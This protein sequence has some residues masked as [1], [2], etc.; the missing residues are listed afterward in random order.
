MKRPILLPTNAEEI[1]PAFEQFQA[2]QALWR[3]LAAVCYRTTAPETPRP[4]HPYRPLTPFTQADSQLFYGREWEIETL[5]TAVYTQPLIA[6]IGESGSGKTSLIQAGLLPHLQ[7]QQWLLL[8]VA[9]NK[10]PFHAL[11]Q[12]ILALIDSA[13]TAN[14][15]D[16]LATAL[17]TNTVPLTAVWQQMNSLLATHNRRWLIIIDALEALFAPT[18]LTEGAIT[19]L[20]QLL[21]LFTMGIEQHITLLFAMRS[22][23]L[24]QAIRYPPFSV[25]LYEHDLQLGPVMGSAYASIIKQPAARFGASF[26]AGLVKRIQDDLGNAPTALPLLQIVLAKLWN[27]REEGHLT[28]R[29]YEKAGGVKGILR[30]HAASSCQQLPPADQKAARRLI[31]TLSIDNTQPRLKELPTQQ[32]A[33]INFLTKQRILTTGENHKAQPVVYLAHPFFGADPPKQVAVTPISTHPAA[34]LPSSPQ[35]AVP[36]APSATAMPTPQSTNPRLDKEADRPLQQQ[37]TAVLAKLRHDNLRLGRFANLLSVALAFTL[38]LL[39]WIGT[40]TM[41]GNNSPVDLNNTLAIQATLEVQEAQAAISAAEKQAVIDSSSQMMDTMQAQLDELTARELAA[42]ALA[43]LPQQTDEAL[44]L[45]YDSTAAALAAGHPPHSALIGALYQTL[46]QATSSHVLAGHSGWITTVAYAPNGRFLLT[47]DSQG[48]AKLWR[49]DGRPVAMLASHQGW[50]QTAVFHPNSSQI[51]TAATDGTAR[52]WDLEGNEL[53]VLA[54]SGT[55]LQTAIYHPSGNQILT[56]G[57]DGVARLWDRQGNLTTILT[58][59][60]AITAAAFS[61]DGS[62]IVTG[63]S[64]GRI[65]LWDQQ[66]NALETLSGHSEQVNAIA[67]RN[68]SAVF[69]SVSNDNAL[70]LWSRQGES[71]GIIAGHSDDVWQVSFAPSGTQLLTSSADGTARLWNEEGDMLTILR[72]TN[73]VANALYLQDGTQILTISGDGQARLWQTDGTFL[74]SFVGH[75]SGLTAVSLAPDGQQFATASRDATIRLWSLDSRETAVFAQHAEWVTA[76]A[77]SPNGTTIATA[78]R[79]GLVQL[80]DQAGN[81]LSTLAGHQAAI[82]HLTF[83][84]NGQQLVTA[85]RDGYALL[86]HVDGTLIAALEG[87]QDVVQTAVFSPDGTQILTASSDG[88]VK[89][90]ASEGTLIRTLEAAAGP[91][92]AAHFSPAGDYIL[93]TGRNGTA[94]LWLATGEHQAS[95]TAHTDVVTDAAFSPAGSFFATAGRDGAAHLWNLAG[96]QLATLTGHTDWI[97]DIAIDPSG[98]RLVTASSD[99]TARLWLPDGQLLATMPLPEDFVSQ[100]D[101]NHD[102]SYILT[103]SQKHGVRLWDGA[104]RF[105]LPLT[106]L[107]GQIETAVFAPDSSYLLTGSRTGTVRRWTLFPNLDAALIAAEQRLANP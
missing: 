34:P 107:S 16:H 83:H 59:E 79:D 74:G 76:T 77:I 84:P 7:P 65:W 88:T 39:L 32:Q 89:Q 28:H 105:L 67:F 45:L 78:S 27:A 41:L 2:Q 33:P 87:H 64:D 3:R 73:W 100:A 61:P 66:G 72:H 55:S 101:F 26:E 85:G 15:V 6:L 60:A 75:E 62:Q 19:F 47:A 95:F 71:L 54:G 14:D 36:A 63:T 5:L 102:G 21:S 96:E 8:D 69:A 106:G 44:R 94:H 13:T 25:V 70:R 103:L 4:T 9:L 23:T 50:V 57:E 97:N 80:R 37:E 49:T 20:D 91:L 11:A 93:A 81:Y 92:T 48:I 30:R 12:A 38:I 99:G 52:L 18:D 35:R 29:A 22:T 58:H 24:E 51:L 1:Q 31:Q 17:Q 53:A 98:N 42:R 104:G 90:W 46:L 43:M 82:T 10:R 86:W 68:D 40:S 56:A